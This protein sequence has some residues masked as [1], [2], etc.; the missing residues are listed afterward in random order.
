M[1]NKGLK[2]TKSGVNGGVGNVNVTVTKSSIDFNMAKT[3]Y[4][5]KAMI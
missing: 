4:I 5:V 3:V 2:R 1:Q